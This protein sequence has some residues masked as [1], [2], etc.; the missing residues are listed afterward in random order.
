[1]LV[2]EVVCTLRKETRAELRSAAYL[3]STLSNNLPD[4]DIVYTWISGPKP[5]GSLLHHRGHTHTLLVALLGAWLLWSL[6][7]RLWRRKDRS[8]SAP[9]RRLLLG[10]ALGGPVLHL[11]MDFGNNY[12]VHPFWPLSSRWFYGDTIFIV[13]PLWFAATIPILAPQLSRRWLQLLLWVILGVML[14]VCWFVPF[15]PTASRFALLAV[16]AGGVALG[17]LA[18]P[19]VR[20]LYAAS[21]CVLVAALFAVGSARAAAVT[22]AAA[23]A[24]FPAL[25]L[26]DLALTPMPANPCCWEAFVVGEQGGTYRVLRTRVALPPLPESSCMAGVDIHPTA[27]VTRID[28]PERQGVQFQTEYH[29][30][31]SELGALR[32]ADCRFR[33]LLE[34]A[35]IPYVTARPNGFAGGAGLFAGDLRYDRQPEA[36]FSDI[37]LPLDPWQGSCPRFVPG[38]TPPRESLFR[39]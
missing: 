31:A 11:L 27:A 21:A 36:D 22:K 23:E 9:E 39:R 18:S 28:R 25:E 15:V 14:V 1:M 19:R 29:V 2:A 34:F 33:A 10:L 17:R 6:A 32:R 20:A 16:T 5:L 12:G 37:R 8:F 24:A 35:R 38:W 30:A 7:L 4:I 3:L 13:E 26:H